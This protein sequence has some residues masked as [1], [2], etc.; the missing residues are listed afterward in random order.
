M[1][2]R[3]YLSEYRKDDSGTHNKT[4]SAL[5]AQSKQSLLCK[6]W[7]GGWEGDNKPSDTEKIA[8]QNLYWITLILY[9]DR[10]VH[11]TASD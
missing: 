1:L 6:W 3:V 11:S 4:R 10:R 5:E 7:R 8:T 2:I 9:G